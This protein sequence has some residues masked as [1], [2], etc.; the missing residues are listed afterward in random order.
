[1]IAVC[2]LAYAAGTPDRLA[3]G[4]WLTEGSQSERGTAILSAQAGFDAEPAYLVALIGTEPIT[5][6][7]SEVAVAAVS[8]QIEA[9]DGVA[10]VVERAPSADGLATALAVH[11]VPGLDPE[12]TA[13]IGGELR[14]GLDPGSLGFVVGGSIATQDGA[15]AAALD[16]TP[17]L[18]LL[19]L[20]LLL[21]LLVGSVGIKP[22]L[23]ALLG[24]L[25]AG[26]ATVSA[27]GL[28]GELTRI[29][30]IG[31]VGAALLSAVLAVEAGVGLLFRYRE[32]SATLGASREALEYT[33]Q[34]LL[35][36]A[37]IG[38][39]S[40]ALVGVSLLIVPIDSV[41]SI[42]VGVIVASL[43]A[44]PLGTL[45]MAALL[46]AIGG[47]QIGETLPLVP[48][49]ARSD[50]GP[51]AFRAFLA[52][53]RGR[54]RGMVAALPVLIAAA[55]TLP[56]LDSK[57]IGLDP[58]ELPDTEPAA[59]AGVEIAA[60]FGA[61]ANGPLTVLSE[62]SGDTPA[63]ALYRATIARLEGIE[64]VS[65]PR[66]AGELTA[67]DA[68]PASRPQSLAAQAAAVEARTVP[69]PTRRLVSGPAAGLDD[70]AQ[71]LA[72][73]LPLIALVALLGTAALWSALF[74]S[75]FGPLLALSAVIAPL[76]GVAAVLAVFA[77][78]RLTGLL[79]Y[80]DSGAPHLQAFVIV[81]SVLLALGLARGAAFATA[82]REERRLGG[83]AAG[84]LA[85]SGL[86][87]LMPFAVATLTGLAL[88][89]LWIGS[90][91]LPAK[92][93]AVGIAAG[94]AADL[95]IARLVLAPALARLALQSNSVPA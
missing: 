36:A 69:A 83:G 39:F 66:A 51:L 2:C 71:R 90:E 78:G 48:D 4:G 6:P 46:S 10:A 32:E 57:A 41:R 11:T 62:A 82:L 16:E 85:R 13:E 15:R 21:L 95:L 58:A 84:S 73:D 5:A 25:L 68:V 54:R 59:T 89:G 80:T 79:D 35:R 67:F 92:E 9:I 43:L 28:L 74:R 75:A 12:R 40:A 29:E 3:L 1:V 76:A 61:G 55:L 7:S 42:G 19:A 52:L 72:E 93:L 20:P 50:A 45:P 94:L 37:A 38:M 44:P 17:R 65:R 87:T 30:A 77:H 86:L 23:A 81:G 88:A 27:V 34:S 91:L 8:A 24:A 60:A 70:S 49:D 22:A 56:V 63:A 33:L 47:A 31:V 26:G 53:G 64:S 18:L 14:A